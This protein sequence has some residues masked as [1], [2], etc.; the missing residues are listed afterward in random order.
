MNVGSQNLRIQ[1]DGGTTVK[2]ITAIGIDLAKSTFQVLAVNRAERP[3]FSKKVRRDKLMELISGLAPCTIFMEACGSAHYW[4]RRFEEQGHRV[5]LIA[6]QHVK[7]FVV[8]NKDDSKD[9]Q[10]I[11]TCGLRPQ[12]RFVPI[13]TA[14]QLEV[15]ALHRV[16]SRLV[17]ERTALANEIRGLLY[18][19][20]IVMAQGIAKLRA[21]LAAMDE[22]LPTLLREVIKDLGEELRAKDE[23]VER[24]DGLIARESASDAVVR[25][26]RTIP[27]VGLLTASAIASEVGNPRGFKNGREFAAF[28]GLV[29]KHT[30]TGGRTTNLS[31]SK[32]GDKYIRT[33]LVQG[34][35]SALRFTGKKEDKLSRWCEGLRQRRGLHKTAIALANKNA[36]IIWRLLTSE[37]IFQANLAA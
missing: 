3:V 23:R 22:K 31:I 28:L 20:G 10:A 24:Y 8:G 5:R 25:R 21:D 13:K 15:Q 30:G 29:P 1:Q 37:E 7:S 16:R 14:R 2:T 18:E 12:T 17:R 26:L 33:L 35:H 4:G 19:H 11:V 9:A 27:G 36:R 6:G 34:A 32:R